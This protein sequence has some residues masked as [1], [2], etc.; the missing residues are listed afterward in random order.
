MKRIAITALKGGTGK[1]T[2]TFNLAGVMVE[3]YSVLLVDIDPQASL[4]SSFVEDVF[5]VKI[6]IRDLFKNNGLKSDDAVIETD[7]KNISLMPANLSLS[8]SELEIFN[9]VDSQYFLLDRLDELE[10]DYDFILIDGPPNL[11]IYTR[12]AIT[13]A[14]H[15]VV[16]MECGSYSVKSNTYLLELVESLKKRANQDLEILG[17]LINRYDGRRILE[18]NY[19]DIIRQEY[20]GNVFN[21]EIKNSVKY[22]ETTATRT[23]ITM[24]DAKSEHA[25]N[26]RELLTEIEN[27]F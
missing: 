4:S 13:A 6:T 16:P 3:K 10:K 19:N 15:V 21:T 17:F 18:K 23:P 26:F 9:M 2:I 20:E 8:V 5:D 14:T 25:K 27:R 22:M 24:Y 7:F 11:G 1:S 12:M